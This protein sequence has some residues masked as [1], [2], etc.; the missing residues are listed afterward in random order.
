M[1]LVTIRHMRAARVCRDARRVFFEPNGLDWREF[2]RHGLPSE[3][4]RSFNHPIANRVCD[5]AEAEH[6]RKV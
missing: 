4:L 5:V 3:L 1:I 2:V 6:G